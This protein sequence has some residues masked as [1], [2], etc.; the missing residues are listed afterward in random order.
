MDLGS[1][2]G[3]KQSEIFAVEYQHQND[4]KLLVQMNYN[5]EENMTYVTNL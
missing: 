5:A 4:L 2:F 3:E 1:G